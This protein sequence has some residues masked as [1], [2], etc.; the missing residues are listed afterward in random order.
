MAIVKKR[1]FKQA[2]EKGQEKS[3]ILSILNK[4]KDTF[5]DLV[6]SLDIEHLAIPKQINLPSNNIPNSKDDPSNPKMGND[7]LDR[8]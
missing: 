3:E 6:N 1:V 2:I 8:L 4:Y 5:E 7:L